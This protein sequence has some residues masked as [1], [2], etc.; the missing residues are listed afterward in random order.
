MSTE[1]TFV[2]S[3][4]PK[5]ASNVLWPPAS[6]PPAIWLA[7]YLQTYLERD[8]RS[9]ANIGD[10]A[11]FE[12]FLALH[13]EGK[14]NVRIVAVARVA[15]VYSFLRKAFAELRPLFHGEASAA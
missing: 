3:P 2:A 1:W 9:L 6:L 8:V 14:E 7:D 15:T 11:T 13:K 4:R 12:R 10:L 5:W